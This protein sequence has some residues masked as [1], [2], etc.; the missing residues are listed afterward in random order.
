[1]RRAR[2]GANRGA[3]QAVELSSAWLEWLVTSAGRELMLFASVGILL[4]GI[5]DLLFDLLWL[6]I[7]RRQQA[8]RPGVV[9]DWRARD[10]KLAIFMPAW[11]EAAVL[12][13]TLR[14]ALA[15]WE[16]EDFRLYVGCYPNDAATL[17]AVSPLA[18]SDSR[19]R[20]VIGEADGPTTK[21]DNLNALWAALG[22]DE[23][24]EGFR[25]LGIVLHDAE[26]YVHP[27]E[28]SL[29]RRELRDHA[30]V[31]IP[32]VPFIDRGAIW[33]GGHYCDE[34]AEAHGKEV[35]L[36]SQL[37]LPVPSAGVGCAIS[38]H[39]VALLAIERGG[40]PFR[41][42]SLTEDYELGMLIGAYGLSARFVDT[43]GQGRDP[44]VS[45]G[46]FPITI[47]TAV[48]QKSRWIAGIALASWDSLGWIGP[49]ARRV[50]R[51]R[52]HIWLTRWMLW[53]DR[54]APL[55]AIILLTAYL[56]LIL[57]VIGLS[58]QALAGWAMPVQ[59]EM[60][61]TLF[62]IDGAILL[63]RLGMRGYFTAQW[64]GLRQGLLSLPRA[65]FANVIAILA[66]RRAVMIYWRMLRSG[67]I[68][69]EK[70]EHLESRPHPGHAPSAVTV[71]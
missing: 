10:G 62:A 31:Q 9:P 61:R 44:V 48:R 60:R 59:D 24:A 69:W 2:R 4:V 6:G 43:R 7:S 22:E 17:F 57:T 34:F 58:G 63:W 3:G 32:V 28:L 71:R 54:R 53:R 51:P 23:R 38:R 66:A 1:V 19:L 41:A 11:Q 64:Y 68:L 33:I 39:T 56:S 15:A 16:G 40:K 29:Y 47:D 45:R 49:R 13:A 27:D 37:G 52:H 70:T 25:F 8:V 20:I 67:K 50:S 21:G 30:M 5:D 18:A 42:E 14:R 55:A 12:P 35:A 65:F 36:R 26:D 46:S